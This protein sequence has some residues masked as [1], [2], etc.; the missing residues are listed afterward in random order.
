MYVTVVLL[1][2]L[3]HHEVRVT[4]NID[5]KTWTVGKVKTRLVTPTIDSKWG[6]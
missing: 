6:E 3:L 4:S 2:N 5:S 1:A